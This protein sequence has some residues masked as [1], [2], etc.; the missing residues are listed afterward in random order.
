MLR[1]RYCQNNYLCSCVSANQR[2]WSDSRRVYERDVTNIE[3][4]GRVT[5][6][7][8]LNLICLLNNNWIIKGLVSF[9]YIL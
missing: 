7:N 9:I 3:N 4:F 5:E 2:A 6:A 8:T 1:G